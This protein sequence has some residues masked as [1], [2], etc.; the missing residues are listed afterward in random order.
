MQD[1]RHILSSFLISRNWAQQN[2]IRGLLTYPDRSLPLKDLANWMRLQG[3]RRGIG[4]DS[5]LNQP[6]VRNS[7]NNWQERDAGRNCILKSS[8]RSKLEKENDN[9]ARK[10]EE[11]RIVVVERSR[12]RTDIAPT[13]HIRHV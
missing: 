7:G 9:D 4:L 2:L 6:Q 5:T 1:L 11:G 8:F 13:T 10:V 3:F 12:S